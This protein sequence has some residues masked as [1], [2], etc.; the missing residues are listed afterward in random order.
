LKLKRGFRSLLDE[1]SASIETMSTPAAI[2]AFGDTDTVFVDLRDVRELE[3]EGVIPGAFHAPR[4]MIEFWVD[5][6]SPYHKPIFSSGKRFLFF[7]AAGWRS[8]LTVKT[9]SDMGMERIAHID[10]GFGAWKQQGGPVERMP[11]RPTSP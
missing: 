4:G 7:C 11:P 10:G 9:L 5:P 1:A 6:D 8:A 3:R 2:A